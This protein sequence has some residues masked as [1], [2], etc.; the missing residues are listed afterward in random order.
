MNSDETP[1]DSGIEPS[2]IPGEK[3]DSGTKPVPEPARES[4]EST[5]S[6]PDAAAPVENSGT[7]VAPA[8][9]AASGAN[10]TTV[11]EQD[12]APADDNAVSPTSTEISA[13]ANESDS[14]PEV[15]N[16]GEPGQQDDERRRHSEE[17]TNALQGHLAM[18]EALQN[19]LTEQQE[20]E[21]RELAGKMPESILQ[22]SRNKSAGLSGD[23][24]TLARLVKAVTL[25]D[26]R[27]AML[28][29][30]LAAIDGLSAKATADIVNA[31]KLVRRL[32]S[33]IGWP[34]E[35][36]PAQSYSRLLE[37]EQS[38]EK[39][40]AS[41][42][43]FQTQLLTATQ[44][45][46]GQLRQ[47]LEAGNSTEA[48]SMWDR[49]QGNISNLSGRTQHELKEQISDLRNQVNELR[50]WKKFAA[51]EKKKELITE[52]RTLLEAELQP[53]Q[54][55]AGIRKLHDSWKQLGFSEQ[56]EE[57]WQQFKEVSDQAY[58]PCKEYFQQRKGVMA[59]NLK[60]RNEICAKL[61][62]F[63]QTVDRETPKIVELRDFEKHMQEE[64]KKY[65]PIEQSKIK[66]LQKRYYGLLDQIRDIRRTSSTANGELKKA[67]VQQARELLELEDRKDA[68]EQA[69]AL[70]AEWKKIGPAAYREDRKY[71]EEFRAACDALFK[72]RDEAK[73][74]IR[75]EIDNAVQ[76]SSAILKQLEDLLSIDEETLRDS[77]KLF[78][79]LQRD[80]NQ[81][82]SPRLKKERRQLQ[83]QFNGLI[84]KIEARFR[85]LPDKK[86]LQ[87]LAA[88]EARSGLCLNLER[89]L[90]ACSDD[91][92]LQ[93]S[94]AEFDRSAWEALEDSGTPEFEQRMNQRLDALLKIGSVEKLHKLQGETEQL[95][96]RMLVNAEIRANLES[97]EQD[98]PLRMEMQLSQL[99]SNFGKAALEE[100]GDR[101]RQGWE[102]QLARLCVGP[103][104]EP[105]REE[106]QQR[107]DRIL[108]RL[109]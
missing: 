10:S 20:I 36:P 6:D 89:Q 81:N 18:L 80:F 38:L 3:P 47:T 45:L 53:P 11:P 14:N 109:L 55:A 23:V 101:Q 79:S 44:E 16:A 17:L 95:A 19:P 33:E 46:V 21:L 56:N 68:M 22:V 106:F 41:N 60:Q 1:T 93:A 52:M 108:D 4:E 25:L 31:Q 77:R 34:Q 100:A 49:V 26:E 69:K 72:Q 94:L 27:Q 82:F 83:D 13:S 102:F 75:S 86:Q 88:L 91:Q 15:E 62:S 7:D 73:K 103:L 8:D 66:K 71:W 74:A 43:E 92:S 61:E 12:M 32:K 39:T 2:S 35:A 48:G 5:A 9:D 85:K 105:V 70:Q 90:L 24:L 97:P 57:L 104:S 63:L 29:E 84:R 67:M 78:A 42:R 98:R 37:A 51:A 99:Q 58:A 54:K 65:A 76:A 96:R 87:A 40:V 28:T 30:C 107:A 50:E 64:W 59:E